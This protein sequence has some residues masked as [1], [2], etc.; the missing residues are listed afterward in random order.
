MGLDI[1]AYK[2]VKLADNPTLDDEGYPKDEDLIKVNHWDFPMQAGELIDGACYSYE[3]GESFFRRSYGGYGSLREKIAFIGGYDKHETEM[4]S[5]GDPEFYSK[6]YEYANP[7][8]A[9]AIR[10]GD[11]P[12][13]ELINFSDCEGYI[14]ADI[15]KKLHSDFVEHNEKAKEILDERD[16]KDYAGLMKSFEYAMKDGFVV[17]C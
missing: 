15:C 1:F 6:Y 7:Y 14:C 17:F 9:G 10:C 8:S 11:G 13:N 16:Y 3:E 4:P 5:Y 12:F 2:G